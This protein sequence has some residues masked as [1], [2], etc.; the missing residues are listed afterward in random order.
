MENKTTTHFKTVMTT[1]WNCAD[2]F[3]HVHEQQRCQLTHSLTVTDLSV[4]HRVCTEYMEQRLLPTYRHQR[5]SV[6]YNFTI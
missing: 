2:L 4:V 5:I 3:I 1:E 6:R